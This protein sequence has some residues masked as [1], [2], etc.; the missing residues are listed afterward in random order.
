MPSATPPPGLPA[1]GGRYAQRLTAATLTLKGTICHLCRRAG[2]DTADHIIP[3]SKG[4]NDN[5]SNLAPAHH[6]CNSLRGDMD[7]CGWF[8]RHPVPRRPA[9]APSR[10]W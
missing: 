4:G 8:A 1:W 7:L 5:L 3:R 2:A 9:P 10:Q 6:G